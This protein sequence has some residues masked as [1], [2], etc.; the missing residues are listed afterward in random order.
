MPKKSAAQNKVTQSKGAKTHRLRW[1]QQIWHYFLAHQ[2]A[3]KVGYRNI[4]TTPLTTF[5]TIAAIGICLAFPIGLYLFVKNIQ[6]LTNGWDQ[7]AALSL[8]THPK[9]SSSQIN[10]ILTKIK[11]YPA[12]EKTTYIT[13]EKALIEF[14][15][16]SNFKD[17]LTLLPENP[18]PGVINIQ[19]NTKITTGRELLAMKETLSTLPQ[20]TSASFDYEW[21]EK[22]NLFLTF[23]KMLSHFLY[24]VIGFGVILM[25]G[26]TIR[27]ALERHRDEIE[28]F[29]LVGATQSYIRRP[30]LYRGI[31]Y[32]G[33][34]GVIAILIM[35]IIINT[36]Q[37]PVKELVSLYQGVFSLENLK[38]YDTVALLAASAGLGW[39]GA[40]VA[41]SQQ[42]RATS[43]KNS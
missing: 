42:Q 32:G 27:L 10:A 43:H 5:L 22:L 23:G 41:F 29:N 26:N 30:F 25:V 17:T 11:Q 19:L 38:F 15:A 18:L 8:Y 20:V 13:P 2:S 21:M 37:T 35:N 9:S 33:L 31:L 16:A 39:L 6:G 40:I 28:V 3:C 7:S 1:H 36:L 12:V 14:E 24:C 34:G 4:S